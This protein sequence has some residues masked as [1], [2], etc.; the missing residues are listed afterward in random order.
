[1]M[2]FIIRNFVKLFLTIFM[3]F[4][5]K[6]SGRVPRKGA[7][8]LASNHVSHLDPPAIA[9]ASPRMVHFMARSTLFDNWL[10]KQVIGRCGLI[11][12]KRGEG[13]VGAMKA[14]IRLL[15]AGEP[16]F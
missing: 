1:M 15:K 2:Y 8:I 3:G 11:P 4:K 14:A 6:G 9:S 7:F 12:V 13:D 10:F 5:A 16:V